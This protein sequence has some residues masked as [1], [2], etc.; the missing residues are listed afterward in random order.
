MDVRTY[1]VDVRVSVP[2][3]N[4]QEITRVPSEYPRTRGD[5]HR[6]PGTEAQE[7]I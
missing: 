1:M 3:L 7:T 6:F 2:F 5:M 4:T